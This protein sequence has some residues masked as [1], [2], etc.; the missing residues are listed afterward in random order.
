MVADLG[1]ELRRRPAE[2]AGEGAAEALAVLGAAGDAEGR[3]AAALHGE[4]QAAFESARRARR[5][6]A[7]VLHM[8]GEAQAA[9]GDAAAAE[10]AAAE[11]RAEMARMERLGAEERDQA[12]QVSS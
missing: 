8:A 1:A 6:E 4:S 3:M 7:S 12:V 9:K 10:A 11:A 2:G 5:A